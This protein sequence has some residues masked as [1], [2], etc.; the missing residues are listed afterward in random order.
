[1]NTALTIGEGTRV[2]LHFSVCL[3]DGTIVDSTRDRSPATF[4][5]GDGNLLPGFEK[6]LFGLK[7]GDRRSVFLQ[8][9]QAFGERQD[10]NIQTMRRSVFG[11]MDL[12]PGLVVSFADQAKAE[13]PGVVAQIHEDTVEVDFNHPLAGR[14]LTFE[15]DIISVVAADTQAVQ[16][17]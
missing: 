17:Q 15:V 12:E 13:L 16:L 1:M 4:V 5:V 8:A 6:A 3:L 10:D 11:G 2:T 9:A 14:D 7:A